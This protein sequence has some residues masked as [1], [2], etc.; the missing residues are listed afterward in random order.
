MAML[1]PRI[2]A[3]RE[4]LRAWGRGSETTR[5]VAK[6]SGSSGERFPSGMR[7]KEPLI[8]AILAPPPLPA[9]NKSL[10]RER[11][12]RFPPGCQK[13]CPCDLDRRGLGGGARRGLGAVRPPG[14]ERA[15]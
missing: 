13:A 3:G 15:G 12:E 5:A 11:S 2:D 7:A 10:T 9:F 6:S 14:D 1:W 4:K 8:V